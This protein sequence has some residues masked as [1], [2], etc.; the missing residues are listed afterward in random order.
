[1]PR[2]RPFG[3]RS[4]RREDEEPA[5]WLDDE[6]APPEDEALAGDLDTGDDAAAE[7][8]EPFVP[9]PARPGYAS[10]EAEA[11]EPGPR[12]RRRLGVPR[13]RRPALNLRIQFGVLVL[14]IVLVGGG[15]FGT[16]LKQGRLDP[17]IEEWWPAAI[18]AVA[19]LWMLAALFQRRIASFLG[20]AAAA[21]VGLS[22]LMDTQ[23]IAAA[24]QTLLGIVLA[25]VGLGIV[26]RGFLLRQQSTA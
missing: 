2:L 4:R 5:P 19:G 8:F 25:T 11:Y 1:M 23:D 13:P 9:V 3:R 24:E 12:R 22:L 6:L 10:D 14:V 20:G 26:I 18:I 17:E 16:L 7:P 15:I 21:G